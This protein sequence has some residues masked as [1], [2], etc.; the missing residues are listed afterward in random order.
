VPPDA[1]E[2]A[3]LAAVVLGAV[4]LGAVVLGTPA[5]GVLLSSVAAGAPWPCRALLAG[6]LG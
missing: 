1:L 5:V 6:R 3:V 2:A 4:V